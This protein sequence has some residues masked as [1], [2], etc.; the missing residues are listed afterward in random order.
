[1]FSPR[2]GTVRT[3]EREEQNQWSHRADLKIDQRHRAFGAVVEEKREGE[4]LKGEE[5]AEFMGWTPDPSEI[6]PHHEKTSEPE[7]YEGSGLSDE[8]IERRK[9]AEKYRRRYSDYHDSE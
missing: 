8:E 1:M 2:L 7:E 3:S 9:K 6:H 5:L 4:L